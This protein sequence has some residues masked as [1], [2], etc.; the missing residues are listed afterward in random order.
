MVK[1]RSAPDLPSIGSTVPD[2]QTVGEVK[3][4]R[5]TF[6]DPFLRAL[7]PSGVARD[8]RDTQQP[9]LLAR[10]LPSGLVQF[11][12][13]YRFQGRQRRLML[14]EYSAVGL[15]DARKR[16]RKA[17]SAVDDGRDPAAERQAAKAQRTDTVETLAAEYLKL[18]ARKFKRSADEDDRIL[19]V[20]VLPFWRHRSVRELTRRDVRTLIERKADDAPVMA[21][22]V[23]A[24]VR[25]MLNFAVD[26]DWIDAN[27]AARVQKPAPET[28]R[29]RVLTHDEIRR[30]WRV[31]SHF[32]TTAERPA[33]GRRRA[34]GDKDDPLCPVS[35]WLAAA[36]KVRLLTA[37]R[38]GEVARM[39]WSDLEL[40][41]TKEKGTIVSGWWTI[42]GEFTKNGEPHRVPITAD[43]AALI[44]GRQ[45]ENDKARGV[46][47][48][49]FDGDTAAIDRS[50]KAS[51]A[52]ARALGI[53]FRGHDLR[54]TAAT[55]MAEAGIPREHIAHVLNHVEGGARATRV[56]DRY[57]R[58][59][60]K[61]IALEAW[62]RRL[63]A[64]L[65]EQPKGGAVVPFITKGA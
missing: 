3:A 43:V 56:Y 46:Y 4:R 32:P 18:H 51:A 61:R 24:V 62:E 52:L 7:R 28:S 65:T 2:P 44:E 42:P 16:A 31:L 21:N 38:G 40:E 34:H 13:R 57:N 30:L 8:Y 54:R 25:K 55:G 48:F 35:P 20:D 49:S 9:G 19:G 37:Q 63:R 27:P 6:T 5:L 17:L 23:L 29:D 33:P 64:I 47:V 26:H 45:P 22:R 53:D 15:A 14:G 41:R 11:S 36:F 10:V 59:A 50:K 39:R 12:V 1:T 60:E 58:D